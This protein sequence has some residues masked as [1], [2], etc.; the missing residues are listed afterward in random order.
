M[1][2]PL[3]QGFVDRLRIVADR[4]GT[5]R[6][7]AAVAG[8]SLDALI[9]Y[10]RGGNQP[11][12]FAMSRMC[13]KAGLSMHWL[14]GGE[15]A[16]ELHGTR[17]L[18]SMRGI[19]IEGFGESKD[20]GWFNPQV[21]S[22]QMTLELP[23]PKAFATTV[24]GQSLIPEGIQPGFMCICSPMQ[25]VLPSDIVHLRRTDGLCTLRVFVGEEKDWLVLKAYTDRD[26]KGVQ[27][28]FEDRIKMSTITDMAPVVY[29]RRK[30]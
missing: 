18:S 9:R 10:L 16:M 19:P 12:F 6:E 7:A 26:D 29:V 15:G 14:A 11:S 1:Q 27:R 8:V 5:R 28:A 3:T 23:D 25:K 30:V 21:S 13:D 22:M 2:Q 17:E 4:L 20:I 24:Q